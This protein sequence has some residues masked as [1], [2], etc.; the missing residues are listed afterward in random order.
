MGLIHGKNGVV[1][2][3]LINVAEVL[4]FDVDES[5][6]TVDTTAMGDAAEKHEVGIPSWNGSLVCQVEAGD[7]GQKLLAIG[8]SV[9][10]ALQPD[11]TNATELSGQ[12][13]ITDRK[14]GNTKDG[15]TNVNIT[16]KGNGVLVNAL[17]V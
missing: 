8:A 7:A 15:M 13:S 4:S 1:K 3:G 16:F 5:V 17:M 9:S 2:V 14:I 6:G 11:G 10:L 12:A